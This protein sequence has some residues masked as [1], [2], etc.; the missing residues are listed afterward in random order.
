MRLFAEER[1]SGTI[2]MLLTSPVSEGTVVLGKFLGA[3]GFFLT[4]WAPTLV[5][6]F[7]PALADADRPRARSASAYL[8]VALLGAYFLSV[9][10]SPRR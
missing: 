9:G 6:V 10:T 4:L 5:Y 2:E 1:K 7:D 3:L 8:A